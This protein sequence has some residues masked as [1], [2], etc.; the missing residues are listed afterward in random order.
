[1]GGQIGLFKPPWRGYFANT[2]LMNDL[3]DYFQKSC[4]VREDGS[5]SKNKNRKERKC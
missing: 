5:R 4:C 3:I 1:M 2:D